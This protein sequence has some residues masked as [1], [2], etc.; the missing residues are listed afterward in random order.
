[1][2]YSVGFE[3]SSLK[4]LLSI[5]LLENLPARRVLLLKMPEK[6][7]SRILLGSRDDWK[8]CVPNR[9]FYA[10]N[11]LRRY[12]TWKDKLFLISNELFTVSIINSLNYISTGCPNS[13]FDSLRACNSKTKPFWTLLD[14]AKMCLRF[15]HFFSAKSRFLFTF[16]AVCLQ[17][18]INLYSP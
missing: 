13:I 3:H 17:K 15:V 18:I 16:S 8:T 1:M 6:Y 14:K 7:F 4:N 2:S 12:E 11:M 5:G 10:R 9:F